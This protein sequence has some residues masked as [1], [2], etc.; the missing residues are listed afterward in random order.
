MVFCSHVLII[1]PQ[2]FSPYTEDYYPVYVAVEITVFINLCN[3]KVISL[4]KKLEYIVH[5][6]CCP[7]NNMSL[8]HIWN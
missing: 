2:R 5:L 1:R 7:Y 4:L 8:G 6:N 3:L